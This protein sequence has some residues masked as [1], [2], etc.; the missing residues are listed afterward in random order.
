MLDI[1]LIRSDPEFVRTALLRRID[2]V[3]LGPILAADA[4]RRKLATEVDAVRSERNRQA[5]EIGK[6][7]ASGADTVITG[8]W[9][10]DFALL[11]KAAADAGLQANWYTYYAG[12]P[13]G[14]TAMKQSGLAHS[15]Y[16]VAEGIPNSEGPEA[17]KFETDFRAKIA[18]P[19]YYP[20]VVNEIRMLVNAMQL[21]KSE[22]AR[23]VAQ[24]LEGMKFD[25]FAGGSGFMRAD[26]HQFFQPMY[27]K[28]FG[29]LTANET[30]D[31]EKTGWGW[32]V[33][34]KVDTADTV[35]PTVCKMKRPNA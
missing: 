4:H 32:H 28:S 14:P 35:L 25:V 13:G 18:L 9:G 1:E 27:I 15:V 5:K 3:D 22:D 7:K 30:F 11:L 10:P 12:G 6:L 33:V 23:A 20:R 34:A 24:K 19:L 2:D 26:D 8:N 21:A 31:E 16:A 17:M 29:D